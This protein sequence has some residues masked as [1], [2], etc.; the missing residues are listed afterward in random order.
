M[1][2]LLGSRR[3][4]K[5]FW[6]EWQ[7]AFPE[8]NHER[9]FCLLILFSNIWTL[10]HLQI[11]CLYGVVC[12]ALWWRDIWHIVACPLKARIVLWEETAVTQLAVGRQTC[13]RLSQEVVPWRRRGRH[14]R[15][16]CCKSLH[17]NAES[18]CEIDASLREI[19]PEC[20]GTST[21]GRRY[22]A[23]R[24]IHS[25]LRRISACCIEMQSVRISE[26]V[27]ITCSHES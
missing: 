18:C 19:E 16:P 15:L 20:K 14:R 8:F 3:E 5:R 12:P 21:V 9:Y 2:T 7:Q 6:T 10:P 23:A 22:P 27:K 13:R 11:I 4:D 24:W 26:T 1:F 25:R 17:S